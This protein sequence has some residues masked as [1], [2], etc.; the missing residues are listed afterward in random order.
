MHHRGH[1]HGG[2]K[3]SLADLKWEQSG[4]RHPLFKLAVTPNSLICCLG[5]PILVSQLE[6]WRNGSPACKLDHT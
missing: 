2:G 5:S 6:H 3:K 1:E 4:I